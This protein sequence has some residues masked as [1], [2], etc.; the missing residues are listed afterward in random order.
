MMSYKVPII[1]TKV[2][3]IDNLVDSK[4]CL[5]IPDTTA[6]SI[7]A[8][9]LKFYK[10]NKE[11]KKLYIQNAYKISLK[12]RLEKICKEESDLYKLLNEK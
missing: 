3:G 8:Y 1:A 11:K 4:S 2:P 6:K 12:Y 10:L 5:L 7:R 9:I